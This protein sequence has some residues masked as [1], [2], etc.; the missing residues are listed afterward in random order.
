MSFVKIIIDV[1]EKSLIQEMEKLKNTLN[2]PNI[3]YEVDNLLLGDVI[4]KVNEEVKLII[5]RK[6]VS[7]LIASIYDK[8]Y[9]EQSFRLDKIEHHNHNIVYLIEGDMRKHN[10]DKQ[11][12]YSAV[13]GVNYFK[14]FSVFRSLNIEESGYIIYNMGVKLKIEYDKNKTNGFYN[15]TFNKVLI[16][17]EKYEENENK[18]Y[19][20]M[21][22]T[23]KNSNITPN[24]ISEIMLCN[25][26]TISKVTAIAIMDKF[27]DI[28]NLINE[29]CI[30][31]DCMNEI[32]YTTDKGKVRKISGS[33]IKNI[34]EYL[35]K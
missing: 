30:N 5:E 7:D 1:R 35:I 26:P 11:M 13:F 20:S 22:S 19:C 15:N 16:E 24:N 6:S 14:G 21:V 17:E 2:K 18:E 33:S 31:P 3:I 4:I 25:I 8:R 23:K 29:L 32:S 9:E 10:K 12:I 28:G 27:G 34:L